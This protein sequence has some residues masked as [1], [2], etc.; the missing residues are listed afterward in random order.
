MA[1]N[2]RLRLSAVMIVLSAFYAV[3]ITQDRQLAEAVA[4]GYIGLLLTVFFL[5]N[6]WKSP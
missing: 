6:I 4:L 2:T 5:T 3:L 1:P